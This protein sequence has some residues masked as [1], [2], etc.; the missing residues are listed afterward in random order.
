MENERKIKC[1]IEEN[2]IYLKVNDAS[3]DFNYTFFNGKKGFIKKYNLSDIY[4][5]NKPLLKSDYTTAAILFDGMTLD[6][7]H[8][9]LE[10][11]KDVKIDEIIIKYHSERYY[12]DD[13]SFVEPIIDDVVNVSSFNLGKMSCFEMEN[14]VDELANMYKNNKFIDSVVHELKNFNYIDSDKVNASEINLKHR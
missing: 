10:V 1:Y 13:T 7:I 2:G 14:V 8:N 12:N 3:N 4:Y 9:F 11:Y 5:G 6:N